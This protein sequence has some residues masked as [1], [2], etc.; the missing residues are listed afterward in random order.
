M[1]MIDISIKKVKRLFCLFCLCLGLVQPIFGATGYA[2]RKVEVVGNVLVEAD[3]L[4]ALSG[5]QQGARVD[6]ST[7]QI[8]NAIRKIAK[9]DG[10]KFVEI[11]LDQVDQANGLANFVIRVEEYPQLA[12]YSLDGLSKK[13]QKALLE[14]VPIGNR[15]ALSPLFLQ[16]ITTKIKKIFLEKGFRAVQVSTALMP[17][18]AMD[19]KVALKIKIDKGQKSTIHKI[20]FQ[21]NAHLDAN[22]LTYHMKALKEGPRFTLVKDIL[23]K[24]ITLV[25]IRKGGTLLSLPKTIEDV[26]RYFLSHVCL[27][28]SVFTEEKYLKAKKELLRFYQSQ[29]F[30]D[31]AIIEERLQPVTAGKLNVH[32]NI[33]EGK[34]YML[35]HVKWIGNYLYSDE[36]LNRLLNLKPGKLYDPI[37]IKSRL[38]PGITDLTINNLY[39]DNGYLFF[40]A[41]VVETGI[42]DNQIDLEIRIQEGKQV[43]IGQVDIVGN[44]LTHDYVI[45]R[46]LRTLPGEK[47]SQRL[48]QES[49]RNLYMLELFKPEKLIPDIRPNEAKGTVDLIYSVEEQPKFD[50]KL[51]GSYSNGMGIVAGIALGSNNVCLQNLF[52]GKIPIGA[53]Q[54]LH[55]KAE[56]QGKDYKNFSFSF[57]EPWLWL[58]ESR[59]IFSI[60][61]DSA[62]QKVSSSDT[63][64]SLLDDWVFLNIFPVGEQDVKSKISSMGGRI[65]L[66]K[67][68]ARYWATHLGIGYHRHTYQ[69]YPLLEDHKKRSGV[70]HDFSLE[71]SLNHSS[72]NHPHYPTAGWEWS[73]ALTLTPPYALFGY[74]SAQVEGMPRFKEYG[75]FITDVYYFKRLFGNCVLHFRGHAGFLHSLSNSAIGPFERFYLGGTSID[76]S[77]SLLGSNVV[78]LRGYPNDSLTPVDYTRK[79][80]GGVLFNKFAS[81]LRYPL[82]LAPICCYLLGFMDIGDSWLHYKNFNLSNIK[83][84]IGGGVR[85]SLPIPIIPMLGLDFAYRLDPVKDIRSAKSS[86]EYHFTIGPAMR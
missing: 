52:R 73:N 20:I 49:L 60:S 19:K 37:Y 66:G 23:K 68:F 10:I 71:F 42:E 64:R 18:E 82:M 61:F 39:T 67:H 45:R 72:I 47:Y 7:G 75:K 12:S 31:V 3:L 41:E 16:K 17:G 32:L 2:V 85:L 21:G 29:G 36:T 69:H 54:N 43:T 70:L 26:K 38:A 28:P 86:F 80:K 22:L 6:P 25:S 48:M 9:H 33:K 76:M 46:E 15:V 84:S 40:R 57:Q 81:E 1:I 62:Y 34:Q 83:K 50:L 35:R 51:N 56:L 79:I 77:S 78:S 59:Y 74:A 27:F 63:R 13:E 53:A 4:I 14:K 58:R 44:T 8:R 30:R 11:Y 5:L 24:S 65:G 55:L